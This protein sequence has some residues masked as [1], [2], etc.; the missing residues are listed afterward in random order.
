[1]FL[2]A[3]LVMTNLFAQATIEKLYEE[4]QPGTF[5]KGFEQAYVSSVLSLAAK[6]ENNQQLKGMPGSW[7]GSIIIP[8]LGSAKCEEGAWLDFLL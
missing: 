5:P 6:D 1:M 4:L 3:K 7:L 8:T 2:F